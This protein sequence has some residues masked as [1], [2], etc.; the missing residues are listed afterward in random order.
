MPDRAES[1]SAIV[2]CRTRVV[3]LATVN[4][5]LRERLAAQPAVQEDVKSEKPRKSRERKRSKRLKRQQPERKEKYCERQCRANRKQHH[6]FSTPSTRHDM[7]RQRSERSFL[8]LTPMHSTAS[9]VTSRRVKCLQHRPRS[10][11][12][13]KC[14]QIIR[15]AITQ[16]TQTTVY[17]CA[18][19]CTDFLRNLIS[20]RTAILH[21][22]N[23]YRTIAATRR[24]LR[25][26]ISITVYVGLGSSRTTVAIM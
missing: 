12:N 19:N 16:R 13:R 21:Y 4:K 11:K 20:I 23:K 8:G 14:A 18:T 25:R 24:L 7:Q 3:P 9:A 2:R 6:K 5:K 26:G 22:L 10:I 17:P 15:Y 1:N